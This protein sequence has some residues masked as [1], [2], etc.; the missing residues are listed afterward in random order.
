MSSI[1]KNVAVISAEPG[2]LATAIDLC[3]QRIN[4]WGYEQVKKF[5]SV[6]AGLG[7]MPNGFNLE[8]IEP[9]FVED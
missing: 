7:M 1:V 3:K 2:S 6:G 4:V 9:C 8:A 5:R